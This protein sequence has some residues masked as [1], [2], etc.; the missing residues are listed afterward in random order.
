M[1]KLNSRH[2]IF[3]ILGTTIVALKTY[4]NLVIEYA[5]RDSWISL[6]LAS[7]FIFLFS[8]YIL[9]ICK[10]TNCYDMHT[11]YISSLGNIF[12]T[13]FLFLFTL[14]LFLTLIESS[15]IEASGMHVNL[16]LET[17]NWYILIFFLLAA[18]YS[19]KKG[20]RSIIIIT[21]IAIAFIMVAGINL[22]VMTM[23]YKQSKYLFPIL[24]NGIDLNLLI[25][26]I[27]SL[28]LYSSWSIA[29][30][31]LVNIDSNSKNKLIKTNIIALVIVIQMQIV[32]MTG[33][34][35]TFGPKRSVNILYP[36]LIQTQLVRYFGFLESGEFFVMLQMV[37]GWFVKY[38]LTFYAILKLLERINLHSKYNIYIITILIFIFSFFITQNNFTLI[39]LLIYYNYISLINFV[40]V[41]LIVFTIF[42]MKNKKTADN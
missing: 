37:G 24:A 34:I 13:L 15:S 18:V 17:P 42:F 35:M 12:G 5:G 9:W 29:I 8:I 32:S 21:I 30:P 36:K 22:G 23:K 25:G 2:F 1:N 20:L 40:I 26:V 19:I 16:L 27:K 4:P 3:I 33:I 41:P 7:I 10:Q 11:I 31:F 28:G 38:I 6:I 39:N 14:T